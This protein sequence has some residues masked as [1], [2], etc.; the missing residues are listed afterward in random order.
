MFIKEY[1]LFM[2]NELDRIFGEWSM[3]AVGSR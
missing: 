3:S 2:K 1:W